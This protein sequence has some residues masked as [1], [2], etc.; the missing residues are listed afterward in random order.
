MNTKF[1]I[2]L[3]L[4]MFSLFSGVKAQI[5]ELPTASLTPNAA[6]MA[7][8]GNTPVSLFTGT[9][10]ISIP[11]YTLQ[12]GSLS[13]PISLSYHSGGVKPDEHPSW[14]GLGWSLDAG[15]IITREKNDM[16]DEFN[17]PTLTG[18][19]D[20]GFWFT[21]K[22]ATPKDWEQDVNFWQDL[23]SFGQILD[24]E[25]DK[26]QFNFNGYSG[27]FILDY[28]G[29]WE[30]CCDQK[31]TVVMNGFAD[32]PSMRGHQI[33]VSQSKAFSGF[34]LTT[35]EG[36]QYVFGGDDAVEYSIDFAAQQTN[37]WEA[38]AWH[39]RKIIHP[40]GD[41]I[42]FT[43]FRGDFISQLSTSYSA[44]IYDVMFDAHG[45]L[46]SKHFS[47][48]GGTSGLN[49]FG[50]LL[51]PVYLKSIQ[52]NKNV[53]SFLSGP[54]PELDYPREAYQDL[55]VQSEGVFYYLADNPHFDLDYAL[56]NISW[57]RLNSIEFG[58]SESQLLKKVDFKYI[59]SSNERLALGS[60]LMSG[61][62][63]LPEEKYQF[64]YNQ[65]SLLPGY[66]S[67]E[68]DHWGFYN[69]RPLGGLSDIYFNKKANPEVLTYGSLKEI[70][71]PTG[72]KT[73]FEFEPHTYSQ[74][75]P[76]ERWEGCEPTP[77]CI[78]GGIRLKKMIDMPGN[79]QPAIMKEY[80]YVPDYSPLSVDTTR[81]SGILGGSALYA[82]V[83][84]VHSSGKH[85]DLKIMQ[86]TF[87]SQSLLPCTNSLGYHVGY[88]EV[89]EKNGDGSYVVYQFSNLDE[90]GYGDE[91][92]IFSIAQDYTY[93]S[94]RARYRGNLESQKF[95]NR[96]GDLLKE[97]KT[98]YTQ[99]LGS[100]YV[101]S[102]RAKSEIIHPNDEHFV[103]IDKGAVYKIFTYSLLKSGEIITEYGEQSSIPVTKEVSYTYNTNNQISTTSTRIKRNRIIVLDSTYYEYAWQYDQTLAK[104]SIL[105]PIRD[106]YECRNGEEIKHLRNKYI[107]IDGKFP[108]LSEVRESHGGGALEFRYG[109]THDKKGYPVCTTNDQKIY[110]VY[111][112]EF[113]H[114]YPLAEI[115][116]ANS[117]EVSNVLG[118]NL[119]VAYKFQPTVEK[120]IDLLRREL[121]KSLVTSYKGISNIGITSVNDASGRNTRYLYDSYGRLRQIKDVNNQPVSQFSYQTEYA[122]Q[123]ISD[124]QLEQKRLNGITQWASLLKIKGDLNLQPGEERIFYVD[125][126]RF[127]CDYRWRIAGATDGV[128][129]TEEGNQVRVRNNMQTDGGERTLVLYVDLVENGKV[130]ASTE[131]YAVTL[132]LSPLVIDVMADP[133]SDD[134]EVFIVVVGRKDG[135]AITRTTLYIN[136]VEFDNKT[137]E[138]SK[139]D[140]NV[141]F[142][143]RIKQA[144]KKE[145]YLL[146]AQ[147]SYG[148]TVSTELHIN[149]LPSTVEANE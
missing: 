67:N 74:Q 56:R 10:Q 100:K 34:T 91:K 132:H 40:N 143:P 23:F 85:Y 116:N 68:I 149:D 48:I 104:K 107:L 87:S 88:S 93:F 33:P 41:S 4:S 14:V 80:L 146:V 5:P 50:Q 38:M 105:S 12:N 16:V 62:I 18:G 78:A 59:N 3:L 21:H 15:G 9:P 119:D 121:P 47:G 64:K 118:I 19:A 122:R 20:A 69:N 97:V 35:D 22:I 13:L 2:I 6:A 58:D 31:V 114:Q 94:S 29:K 75:L 136:E 115:R 39:L 81:S 73:S 83:E 17:D 147:D 65:L 128:T 70:V 46:A 72:G 120:R 101:Y 45:F 96:S 57:Q 145:Y 44:N 52:A 117:L 53:V 28:Q 103:V 11:L 141:R 127:P 24:T 79:G 36:V 71:Y 30:V 113:D 131:G 51:S 89:V 86:G 124:D 25:P 134:G 54:S 60:I 98:T 130:I 82:L 95:Y 32:V 76:L 126:E 66:L 139:L 142:M 90:P 125:A 140:K 84:R 133:Y 106:I 26:F 42:D 144:S 99:S 27:Y 7:R 102:I 63:L 37:Q 123:G 108:V 109:A 111:L 61:Q 135:T 110:S 1:Y 77:L 138:E 137:P 43:Y 112:W 49:F 148:N 8:F 129:Y 55:W 92:P